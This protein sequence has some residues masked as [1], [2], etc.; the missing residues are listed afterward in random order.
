MLPEELNDVFRDNMKRRRTELGLTQRELAARMSG[1]KEKV[2]VP[3]ISDLENGVK[4]PGLATLA[5]LAEALETSPFVLIA[6][7]EEI[8]TKV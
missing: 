8:S 7:P 4:M 1:K 6:V 5:K 2:H 3:Y